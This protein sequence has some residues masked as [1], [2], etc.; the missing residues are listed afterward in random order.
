[1]T[2]ARNIL[3][4]HRVM[5]DGDMD[6]SNLK[7][8]YLSLVGGTRLVVLLLGGH[9]ERPTLDSSHSAIDRLTRSNLE[10]FFQVLL[11]PHAYGRKQPFL[12]PWVLGFDI[13]SPI[14][15]SC[16]DY[17]YTTAW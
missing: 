16:S 13:Y 14:T 8:T 3:S 15:C 1:M 7:A 4:L 12:E 6:L 11:R 9:F 5:I 10:A 2:F 17:R